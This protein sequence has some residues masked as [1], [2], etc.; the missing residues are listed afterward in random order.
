MN[1]FSTSA[2]WVFLT[3]KKDDTSNRLSITIVDCPCRTEDKCMSFWSTDPVYVD[4][5]VNTT[6]WITGMWPDINLMV[7]YACNVGL[8]TDR[9][10]T[11]V[12]LCNTTIKNAFKIL[13][14]SFD[15]VY[16]M[17]TVVYNFTAHIEYSL[18]DLNNTHSVQK[19]ICQR[20]EPRVGITYQNSSR[21][22][23]NTSSKLQA[24]TASIKWRYLCDWRTI[25]HWG[26]MEIQWNALSMHDQVR[27]FQ[28]GRILVWAS[29]PPSKPL[30]KSGFEETL[31]L[32][33]SHRQ[34]NL[35]L[36]V[37]SSQLSHLQ[38]SRECRSQCWRRDPYKYG[39]DLAWH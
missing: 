14:R 19:G 34:T 31:W 36:C 32:L 26:D 39:Y 13:R 16:N 17:C 35:Q 2:W 8:R 22:E 3:T 5:A 24:K 11:V 20:L 9:P 29:L 12:V 25:G 7:P 6:R 21:P 1:E 27:W 37:I 15:Y 4:H 38:L 18:I 23:Y 10:E 33:E 30:S 28:W